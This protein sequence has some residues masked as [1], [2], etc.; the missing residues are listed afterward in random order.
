MGWTLRQTRHAG[1]TRLNR[2]TPPARRFLIDS[3]SAPAVLPNVHNSGLDNHSRTRDT[4]SA[5]ESARPPSS[6]RAITA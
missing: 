3:S 5:T 4:L 1:Q 2:P 6:S